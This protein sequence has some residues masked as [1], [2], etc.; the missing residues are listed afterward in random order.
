M[1]SRALSFCKWTS[2][3]AHHSC[4]NQ[5][6]RLSYTQWKTSDQKIPQELCYL[7]EIKRTL[8]LT[9]DGRPTTGSKVPPFSN[10]GMD[11]FGHI[12]VHDGTGTR[13]KPA[14]KKI[15]ALIFVCL[16][17]RAVHLEPLTSMDVNSF[18]NAFSRFV[19]I[20][21][22]CKLIRSDHGSNFICAKRQIAEQLE[23]RE[24]QRVL[25]GNNCRWELNPPGASH[26]LGCY[27]RKIGSIRKVMEGSLATM[28]PRHLSR[29]EFSTLLQEA[30]AIVNNTPLWEA[31]YSPDEP[32]PLTPANLLTLRTSPNPPS[33]EEFSSADLLSYGQKRWRRT[34]YLA[35][36]F[37]SRWR[38]EYTHLLQRRHKWRTKKQ[39]ATPG[40]VVLIQDKT[41]FRNKWR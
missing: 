24:V 11:V 38:A 4:C 19:C 28:A 21:G 26:F 27:E 10:V 17:S 40:D 6:R 14:L 7:S 9:V 16:S 15:W 39:C 2:R 36:Q 8:S 35:Q 23:Q 25:D 18:R 32:F 5:T 30:A 12:Y 20:R 29:D 34:Q 13:R 33:I 1:Y 37:W 41:A 3:T 31:S 22:S